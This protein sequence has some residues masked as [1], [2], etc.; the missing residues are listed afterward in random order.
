MR[1]AANHRASGGEQERTCR[2][3]SFRARWASRS[4]QRFMSHRIRMAMTSRRD[5]RPNG[6]RGQRSLKLTNLFR[7]SR[8]QDGRSRRRQADEEE[9]QRHWRQS[10]QSP[11]RCGAGRTRRIGAPSTLPKPIWKLSRAFSAKTWT[12]QSKLRTGGHTMYRRIGKSFPNQVRGSQPRRVR[13]Y[14]ETGI[15]HN[16]SAESYFQCVQARHEGVYQHCSRNI[17]TA[18]SR[19]LVSLQQSRCTRR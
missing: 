17:Y 9:R 3:T 2:L 1:L 19:S 5:A 14:E 7:Q 12:P 10:P 18:I 11:R 15:V 16:N 4:K 8:E 6:R 13:R